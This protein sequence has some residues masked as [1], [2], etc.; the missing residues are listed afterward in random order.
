MLQIS[1]CK[2][3]SKE[4]KVRLNIRNRTHRLGEEVNIQSDRPHEEVDVRQTLAT[5][6]RRQSLSESDGVHDTIL[7][8]H[9][10]SLLLLRTSTDANRSKELP[11]VDIFA[12]VN[13][14]GE[15][16]RESRLESVEE[17]VIGTDPANL[18]GTFYILPETLY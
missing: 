3:K 18:L 17:I 11:N 15:D 4:N 13:S 16:R 12:G 9:D 6:S 2:V 5:Q 7:D 1:C 14:A 10:E 8:G